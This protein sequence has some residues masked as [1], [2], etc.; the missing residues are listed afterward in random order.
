VIRRRRRRRRRRKRR[1]LA[2]KI[3]LKHE[4]MV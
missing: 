1:Q 3:M 4:I 2:I